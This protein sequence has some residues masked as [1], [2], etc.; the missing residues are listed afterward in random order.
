[1]DSHGRGRWFET[2]IAYHLESKAYEF[3][4]SLFFLAFQANV[5]LL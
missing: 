1:M 5:T 3:I 4:V 2:S